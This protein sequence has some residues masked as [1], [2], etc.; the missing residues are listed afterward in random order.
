MD[1]LKL[2]GCF[3]QR[4]LQCLQTPTQGSITISLHVPQK[5]HW[6]GPQAAGT[7][8]GQLK[9]PVLNRQAKQGDATREIYQKIQSDVCAWMFI[10]ELHTYFSKK[11]ELV[12]RA[13]NNQIGS[14]AAIK[15]YVFKE[16]S[17]S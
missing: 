4:R 11:L 7:G 15:I 12:H 16:Y 9:Q 2:L 6:G 13:K 8:E 5:Q 17:L 14:K 3:L 10:T 1:F